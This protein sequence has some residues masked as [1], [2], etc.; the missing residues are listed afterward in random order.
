MSATVPQILPAGTILH[1]LEPHVDDRGS[2]PSPT[3]RSGTP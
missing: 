2:S 1:P 3:A